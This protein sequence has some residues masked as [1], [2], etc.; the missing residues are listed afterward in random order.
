MNEKTQKIRIFICQNI[1]LSSARL[2]TLVIETFSISRQATHVHIQNLL[3]EKLILAKK[4][5]NFIPSAIEGS[6]N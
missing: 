6:Q 3:K 4:K 2:S 5:G 1:E